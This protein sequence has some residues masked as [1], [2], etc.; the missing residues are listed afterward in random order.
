MLF[1]LLIFPS[2]SVSTN[3]RLS[4]SLVLTNPFSPANSKAF[5]KS[6][7]TSFD[8]NRYS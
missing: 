4:T 7:R 5:S 8:S 3:E 1:I 6:R 2:K